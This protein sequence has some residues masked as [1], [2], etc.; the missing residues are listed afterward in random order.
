M[1]NP[2]L[3]VLALLVLVGCTAAPRSYRGIDVGQ[4][5]SVTIAAVDRL[6]STNF[7]TRC[8]PSYRDYAA[9]TPDHTGGRRTRDLLAYY[10][11][12]DEDRWLIWYREDPNWPQLITTVD[13]HLRDDQVSVIEVQKSIHIDL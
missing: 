2:C 8:W 3:T 7:S 1:K 11:F 12:A 4:E 13:V 5:R 6:W 9:N 10:C